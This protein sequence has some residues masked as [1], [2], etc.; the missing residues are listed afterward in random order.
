MLGSTFVISLSQSEMS[1]KFSMHQ[2]LFSEQ[3]LFLCLEETCWRNTNRSRGLQS[4]KDLIFPS[5]IKKLVPSLPNHAP[6]VLWSFKWS[7]RLCICQDLHELRKSPGMPRP[8]VALPARASCRS[9]GNPAQT[10]RDWTQRLAANGGGFEFCFKTW[11]V[12]QSRHASI[13]DSGY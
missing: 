8:G 2:E 1:G 7:E 12:F 10:L 4:G 6:R 9:R 13:H 11:F 3:M 5:W